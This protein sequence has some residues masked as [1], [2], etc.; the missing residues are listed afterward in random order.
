MKSSYRNSNGTTS[1][2]MSMRIAV[3]MKTQGV[4]CVCGR[5]HDPLQPL[6][7]QIH[8]L[9]AKKDGG[10]DSLQNLVLVCEGC[11]YGLHRER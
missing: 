1:I 8:H 6:Q 4:C 9:V 10:Q 2:S 11:H 7:P 3:W 5:K